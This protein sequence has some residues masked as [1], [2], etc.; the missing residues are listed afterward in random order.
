MNQQALK[1]V[2]AGLQQDTELLAQLGTVLQQQYILMSLR[3]SEQLQ[4]LNQQAHQLLAQ[5]QQNAAE[6]QEAMLQLQLPLS[7]QGI[8]TLLAMLP[9]KIRDASQQLF[10]KVQQHTQI[11]QQLNQK[12]GELL[13]YQRGLMQKLLGLDDKTQYPQLQMNQR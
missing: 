3:Q 12:N 2:I 9:E 6:R 8:Q 5:L 11:C 4:Q 7:E 10:D 13:A 1:I